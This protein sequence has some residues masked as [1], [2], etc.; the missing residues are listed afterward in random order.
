[1]R[2]VHGDV[3]RARDGAKLRALRG[4]AGRA[5]A[6]V[7]CESARGARRLVARLSFALDEA[8]DVLDADAARRAAFA[9]PG[10]PARRRDREALRGLDAAARGDRRRR[11]EDARDAVARG[12]AGAR[13]ACAAAMRRPS[14][15]AVAKAAPVALLRLLAGKSRGVAILLVG[16]EA[17]IDADDDAALPRSPR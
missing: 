10:S 17:E 12:V 14:P 15:G 7:A 3:A 2:D 4:S 9:A 1:M 13:D 11:L 8:A 5:G 6:V 16:L